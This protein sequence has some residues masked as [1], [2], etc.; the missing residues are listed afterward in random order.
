MVQTTEVMI[1]FVEKVAFFDEELAGIVSQ[2]RVGK[3]DVWWELCPMLVKLEGGVSVEIIRFGMNAFML[4]KSKA[5]ST[6]ALPGI[7]S[8]GKYRL[9]AIRL[10]GLMLQQKS[11]P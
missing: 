8:C 5:W 6:G 9:Q 10:Q 11:W 1:H 7:G 3:S 4:Q 2:S